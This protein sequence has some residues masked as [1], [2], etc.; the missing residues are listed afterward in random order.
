MNN[1]ISIFTEDFD[2]SNNSA[3]KVMVD[4]VIE[5]GKKTSGFVDVFTLSRSKKNIVKN[6]DFLLNNSNNIRV[7][8][9]FVSDKSNM[10][11]FKRAIFEISLSPR[12][13]IFIL[14]KKK[15][16][17]FCNIIWYSP[18]I[19]WSPLI[20]ILSIFNRANKF[21][22]LRDIFPAWAVDLNIIKKP[23][24][25]YFFFRFFEVLN[26]K[27]AD[28]I[29]IQTPG[30][31]KYFVSNKNLKRKVKILRT[32]YDISQPIKAK[33]DKF[34]YLNFHNKK[35]CV[36]PGNLGIANNQ[37]LLLGLIRNLKE[38]KKFHFLFIGL[39]EKDKK[40]I[41][42]FC[43]E[44]NLSNITTMETMS[45]EDLNIILLNSHL[46]LFSLDMRHKSNPIPGKFLHFVSI[47]LPVFGFINEGNDLDDII[48]LNKLGA[49]FS[50]NNIDD[51]TDSFLKISRSIDLG[52]YKKEE[53]QKYIKDNLT[54]NQAADFIIKTL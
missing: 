4:L 8:R 9:M 30:D 33:K 7:Y 41:E 27:T 49:S 44:Y 48:S 26:Y 28:Y 16:F 18:T 24:L 54:S 21:L 11:L 6:T 42:S 17:S 25:K 32:W 2:D 10:S 39:K 29:G 20:L 40:D 5:L 34:N 3:G 1:N 19:F 53:I 46:G 43:L 50:G 23:S 38:D 13:F 22:I 45:Q 15:L 52:K 37:K 51:A 12:M 14:K 31:A 47:G 35:V 36:Y